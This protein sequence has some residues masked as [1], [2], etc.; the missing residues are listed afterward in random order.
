[1]FTL[2]LLIETLTKQTNTFYKMDSYQYNV[3]IIRMDSSGLGCRLVKH[4]GL[5]NKLW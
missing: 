2:L 5:V 3:D 4:F 1:M